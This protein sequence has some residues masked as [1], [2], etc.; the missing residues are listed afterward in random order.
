[1]DFHNMFAL[2]RDSNPEQIEHTVVSDTLFAWYVEVFL[3]N[4]YSRSIKF[5]RTVNSMD[6]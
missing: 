5:C 4:R 6:R 2:R 1:M 3:Q